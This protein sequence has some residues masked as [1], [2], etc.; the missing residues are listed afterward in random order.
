MVGNQ[1]TIARPIWVLAFYRIIEVLC[2]YRRAIGKTQ[3]EA[4]SL[5]PGPYLTL[6][7]FI[8]D[9]VKIGSKDGALLHY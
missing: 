3:Q 2:L 9:V 7:L 1:H 4:A 8:Q 5:H 6:K